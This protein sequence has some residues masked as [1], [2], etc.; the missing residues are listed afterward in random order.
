MEWKRKDT[1][2][3]ILRKPWRWVLI[4]FAVVGFYDLVIAQFVPNPLIFPR[5]VEI[6]TRLGLSWQTWGVIILFILLLMVFEGAHHQIKTQV[7]PKL[8]PLPNR[9]DLIRT[10]NQMK[11]AGREFIWEQFI[12]SVRKQQEQPIDDAEQEANK[13][14]ANYLQM[15]KQFEQE[16]LV[17]GEAYQRILELFKNTVKLNVWLWYYEFEPRPDYADVKTELDNIA[18]ETVI[19]IDAIC[20]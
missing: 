1:A 15:E 17:A 3:A 18:R 20:Q 7:K 8:I 10:M 19:N 13:A 2:K 12:V 11:E 4:V 14:Y 6:P 5:V 9:L 16:T